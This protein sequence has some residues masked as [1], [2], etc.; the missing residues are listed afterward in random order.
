MTDEQQETI[1]NEALR[2]FCK[3]LNLWW[4]S[5]DFNKDEKSPYKPE[6]FTISD[7]KRDLW[8]HTDW[9]VLEDI[10]EELA[11]PEGLIKI[12]TT[13]GDEGGGSSLYVG[14]QGHFN[15]P[16]D[17]EITWITHIFDLS[18]YMI[19]RE[20]EYRTPPNGKLKKL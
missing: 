9:K 8:G 2:I 6:Q 12:E 13:D 20:G 11:F 10:D 16:K 7:H 5:E 17:V 3:Y 14:L 1:V 4:D 19:Y 15:D 18:P